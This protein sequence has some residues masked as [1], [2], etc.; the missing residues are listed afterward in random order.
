MKHQMK[1]Q[2]DRVPFLAEKVIEEHA[3]VLMDEWAAK[4][5]EVVLPVPLEDI[6]ELHLGLTYE[7]DD[8]CS[9]YG[10]SDILGAIWFNENMIRVDMSL[11]PHENPAKLGRY[12]FTLAHEIAHWRLHRSHLRDDPAAASLFEPNGEPAFVCRS[13]DKPREE[14]QA[15]QFAACLLMPRREL[16]DAWLRWRGSDD[17]VVIATLPI[18]DYHSDR[19]ANEEVAMDRFCR[20]LADQFAVSAQ[21]MRIRLQA[22]DLLVKELEPRLF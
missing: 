17:P 2:R 20:P 4:Q 1:L 15:D 3:R 5:G 7:I 14:R 8:L 19:K 21:A 9:R 12:N 16:R 13:T 10:K 22:L 18:R 11:D 6:I